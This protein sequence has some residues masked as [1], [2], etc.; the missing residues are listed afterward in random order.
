MLPHDRTAGEHYGRSLT[1]MLAQHFAE[2]WWRDKRV[3]CLGR[4]AAGTVAA[5]RAAHAHV[6]WW[7]HRD[8]PRETSGS[9]QS[10][11]PDETLDLDHS[12]PATP[13]FDLVVHQGLLP[14]LRKPRHSLTQALR[15]SSAMVVETDV[16]DTVA[17]RLFE[18]GDR[19]WSSS[20][21][22]ELGYRQLASTAHWERLFRQLD[23]WSHRL[24]AGHRESIADRSLADDYSA[25]I[26]DTQL[27]HPD[28]RRLWLLRQRA[29]VPAPT[30][31]Q[32]S[33]VVQGPI[34]GAD[35]RKRR[36]RLTQLC[37]EQ[38]RRVLPQAE[39]I[40]STWEGAKV[41]GLYA[42]HIVW[43][44]DPGGVICDDV[45]QVRNNVNRQIVSSVG[46]IRRATRPYCLKIRSD[47]LLNSDHFLQFWGLFP[48]R[49]WAY[50]FTAERMLSCS[51]FARRMAGAPG[52]QT[53][54]VFHPSDFLYFGFRDDLQLLFDIPLAP[55]PSTSRWFTF[56]PRPPKVHDCY[57]HAHCRFFPEQYL[58][59]QF[60]NKFL[61]VD[62]RDRL[63]LSN[64]GVRH[65]LPSQ[66]HN[67]VVLDQSQ[68]HFLLPKYQL[69][70]YC[71]ADH[72]WQ[73]L[74]RHEVWRRLYAELA[75]E[76]GAAPPTYDSRMR[77]IFHDS[78]AARGLAWLAPKVFQ[79]VQ[80]R[81]RRQQLFP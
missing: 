40:L 34:S 9:Q 27:W 69:R 11:R 32:I 56:H 4:A 55:E 49:D 63:D 18:P 61:H 47:L 75:G 79:Y 8:E 17:P 52:R 48:E 26:G 51:I 57:A 64:P 60:V 5:L 70:Q 37:L 29:S 7:V 28:F 12:W 24:V 77:Y 3:L 80:R 21:P 46:G 43:N 45:Y 66:L 50:K 10:F 15:V 13:R 6:V 31:D 81:L 74:F 14:Y 30:S 38:L 68:W 44:A 36:Y 59:L 35:E 72:D 71:M 16:V 76:P 39:I 1:P 42:D 78:H 54:M 41:D 33:V 73:G 20:D 25:P 58:W 2:T 67:L 23:C 65:D 22:W 19:F 62:L 53:A